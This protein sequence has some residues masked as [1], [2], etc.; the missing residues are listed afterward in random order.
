MWDT[1]LWAFDEG[2]GVMGI[3]TVSATQD[4]S[5]VQRCIAALPYLLLSS[6]YFRSPNKPRQFMYAKVTLGG[7]KMAY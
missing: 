6:F 3:L 1:V 2:L 5:V 7:Q 4:V